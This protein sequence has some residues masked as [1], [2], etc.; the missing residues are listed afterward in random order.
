MA[1][2]EDQPLGFLVRRLMA[3]LRPQA[4][5]A[6]RPLGLGLPE[7]VCLRILDDDPGRT[8]AELARHTHVT[9]QAMNQVLQGLQ[10]MG[11][12]TRPATAPSGRALPAQLTR[13][14]SALLK[15]AEAAVG[16]ADDQLL[17][18]LSHADRRELKR[19]LFQA[20]NPPADDAAACPPRG[21]VARGH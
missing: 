16:E 9:A 3:R 15:R 13:K 12:V 14:G 1:E 6:L 17:A 8:S 19:L 4:T 11:L 20:G 18:H 5:M 21:A 2:S 7:F 10:D